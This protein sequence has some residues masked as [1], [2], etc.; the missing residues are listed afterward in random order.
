MAGLVSQS[1]H[2]KPCWFWDCISL[3]L[4]LTDLARFLPSL[5]RPLYLFYC[6]HTLFLTFC[7]FGWIDKILPKT[8]LKILSYPCS[9]PDTT[10]PLVTPPTV[11]HCRLSLRSSMLEMYLFAKC[12]GIIFSCLVTSNDKGG[13][14]VP[15]PGKE[16]TGWG[17]VRKAGN[18]DTSL[19][20]ETLFLSKWKEAKVD[21]SWA[22]NE[23]E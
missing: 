15:S 12:L 9:Q 4:G 7:F 23:G 22:S 5:S 11:F 17:V 20:S 10:F 18:E 19:W 6:N 13:M 2:W 1:L 8:L 16:L 21:G 14:L 3:N